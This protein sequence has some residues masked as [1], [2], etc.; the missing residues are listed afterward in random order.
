MQ[1]EKLLKISEAAERLGV[2]YQT[3]RAWA[4]SGK[5]A[6]VRYPSGYR[7]FKPSVIDRFRE[8]MR[9]PSPA[10]RRDDDG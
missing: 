9:T 6:V 3:L 5:I 4:D 8:Q 2:H 7:Y 1:D 10:H